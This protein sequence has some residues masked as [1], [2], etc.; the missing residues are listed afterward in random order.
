MGHSPFCYS[1]ITLFF[2]LRLRPMSMA[3]YKHTWIADIPHNRE[4]SV[5]FTYISTVESGETRNQ[6]KGPHPL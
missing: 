1:R 4:K 5:F 3:I 2:P 6:S